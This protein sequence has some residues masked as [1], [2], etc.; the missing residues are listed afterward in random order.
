M[1]LPAFPVS[2]FPLIMGTA[3]TALACSIGGQ[4]QDNQ[5]GMHALHCYVVMFRR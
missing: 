4:Q 2:L 1:M 5:A 3:R